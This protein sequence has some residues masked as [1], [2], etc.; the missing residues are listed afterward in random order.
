M[1]GLDGL[2]VLEQLAARGT[3]PPTIMLTGTGN[4]RVA[5]EA[6]KLGASDYVVKDI[7]GVYLDLL[8]AV[9]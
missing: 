2:Q 4:E 6:L 1:P 8:P 9:I 7:D 3:F 5:V